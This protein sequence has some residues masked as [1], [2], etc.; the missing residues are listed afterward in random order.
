LKFSPYSHTKI[1]TYYQCPKAFEYKYIQKLKISI[2]PRFFEKGQYYHSVLEHYPNEIDFKFKYTE[3]HEQELFKK[4]IERFIANDH[5]QELLNNK[6][7]AELEFKFDEDLNITDI[8]KWN[9]HLYG[10]IDFIGKDDDIYI[11]DWKSKD[12]GDK[13]PTNKKQLQMYAAWIFKAR[14][15]LQKI[16]C[17]FAYIEN[18]TFDTFEYTRKD[19]EQFIQDI[20]K[21]IQLI[22]SDVSFKKD[23]KKSCTKCD[24]FNVCKP[25]NVNLKRN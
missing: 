8:I 1:E 7:A 24:Y 18:I 21:R 5:V 3:E 15:R 13:Y 22:E 11:V 23:V 16:K 2:D 9:S 4:N 6:F 19:G 12:H 20:N 25:F 10:F 14:P 17:E